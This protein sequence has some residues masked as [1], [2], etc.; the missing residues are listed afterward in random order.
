MVA[1]HDTEL[2]KELQLKGA[3]SRNFDKLG[4]YKMLVKL[5]ETKKLLIKTLKEV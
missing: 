4:N 1:A 3:L 5:S 2:Q